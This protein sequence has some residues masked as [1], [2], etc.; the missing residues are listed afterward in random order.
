MTSGSV[1]TDH[2]AEMQAAMTAE[3]PSQVLGAFDRERAGHAY[4]NSTRKA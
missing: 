4:V 1:I 2:V 3:P